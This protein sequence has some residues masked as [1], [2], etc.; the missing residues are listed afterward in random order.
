M[1][2]IR[3][4]IR[5]DKVQNVLDSLED[6]GVQAFT[7]D[8]TQ[9]MGSHLI[10]PD[11][12]EYSMECLDRYTTMAKLEF[13]CREQNINKYL[14]LIRHNAFTSKSGDG[15]VYVTPVETMMQIR[16]GETDKKGLRHLR[17]VLD[18]EEETG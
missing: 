16:S 2:L 5:C 3:A 18:V 13:I 7:V 10:D 8:H 6:E 9:G 12:A 14:H 4:I 11:N 17:E 15:Y 1:R